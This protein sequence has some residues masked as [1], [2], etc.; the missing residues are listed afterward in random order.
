MVYVAA[1]DRASDCEVTVSDISSFDWICR[2][3]HGCKASDSVLV[4]C[5]NM[6]ASYSL[7]RIIFCHHW[8]KTNRIVQATKLYSKNYDPE[9]LPNGKMC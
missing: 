6:T 8:T 9:V 7:I 1:E 4:R 3:K 2:K 5:H